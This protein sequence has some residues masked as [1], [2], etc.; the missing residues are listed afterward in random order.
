MSDKALKQGK[1][2]IFKVNIPIWHTHT[3]LIKHFIVIGKCNCCS[4]FVNSSLFLKD[5]IKI[6][7]YLSSVS[8]ALLV[9][10]GNWSVFITKTL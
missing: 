3:H 2:L 6:V 8:L 9:L 7:I 5:L 4:V 10:Q 1:L